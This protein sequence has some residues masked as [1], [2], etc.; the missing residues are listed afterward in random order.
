MRPHLARDAAATHRQATMPCRRSTAQAALLSR[1]RA[2]WTHAACVLMAALLIETAALPHRVQA[3]IF[4]E[5]NATL[6]A[7]LGEDIAQLAEMVKTVSGIAM[8]IKQLQMMVEQGKTLLRKADNDSVLGLLDLL[9]SATRS[10]R[11]ID[12]DIRYIGFK[13]G[14]VDK[15]RNSVYQESLRGAAP[16]SF[17]SKAQT[18]NSALLEAS[19]VAMRAQTNMSTLSDR[20]QTQ[21]RI[22][23][24]SQGTDG[25]VGQL[26]L[27][28]RNLALLHADLA[29]IQTTLDT[30]MRVTANMAAGQAATGV[31][32]E[33]QH[34]LSLENYTDPG[35]PVHVPDRLP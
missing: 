11:S 33:E 9:G 8:Q 35:P 25:V 5:E 16:A 34:R 2:R 1:G 27:V 20:A 22:L 10:Y 18:W 23:S 24:D 17:A 26:Q 4:G 14:Q 15:E 29:G 3:S 7:I 21:S 31:M 6:A 19:R 28:V 13:L 32:V 30:G 12:R